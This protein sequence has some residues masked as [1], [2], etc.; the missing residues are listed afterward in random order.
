MNHKNGPVLI[1]LLI[2]VAAAFNSCSSTQEVITQGAGET[3]RNGLDYLKNKQYE[4]ARNEFDVVVKQYPGSAY[5]DSAQYFLAETYYDQEEYLTAAFEYGNINRN[6][7]TSK[8]AASARYQVA[9]CYAAQS[10]RVELDQD[11]TRKAIDAFQSFIDYY[12]GSPLVPDAEKQIMDL[13]D[14][15]AQKNYKIAQ[16]Y[17]ILG[18]YKAAL[19]YYDVVLDQF[20]DS[21]VADKA[22]LGKV[23]VLIIRKKTDEARA[24]LEKF[25]ATFPNSNLKGD[26]DDLARQLKISKD[27][28]VH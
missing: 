5:A 2:I 21:D 10:P 28:G 27:V 16:Q 3:Y 19:V 18:Y 6:Y 4:K 14:K 11:N 12:P 17:L 9:K 23:K 13:R 1:L 20:H 25:Y 15:L 24:A 22:A 26:A 8:L 7:P